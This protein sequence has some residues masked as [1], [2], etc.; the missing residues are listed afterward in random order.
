MAYT[1]VDQL[2]WD[3]AELRARR[4]GILTNKPS[5]AMSVLVAMGYKFRVKKVEEWKDHKH[6]RH[7]F[8]IT[9]EVFEP[10]PCTANDPLQQNGPETIIRTETREV[11]IYDD[12]SASSDTITYS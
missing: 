9:H 4:A 3:S 8:R 11:I 6:A 1:R 10:P 5:D 2:P 12:L 7:V